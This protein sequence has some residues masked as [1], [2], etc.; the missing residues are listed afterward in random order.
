VTFPD[1]FVS[2]LSPATE[3]DLMAAFIGNQIE[4]LKTK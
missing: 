2:S 1:K 4:I 3:S